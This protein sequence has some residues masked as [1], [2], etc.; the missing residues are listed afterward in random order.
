MSSNKYSLISSNFSRSEISY[1]MRYFV[2][3]QALL[4]ITCLFWYLSLL[5]VFFP[6]RLKLKTT[7][8]R[9]LCSWFIENFKPLHLLRINKEDMSKAEWFFL[10][11]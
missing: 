10:Q 1:K 4:N 5:S 6:L 8:P 11:G 2:S 7:F 9:T 3:A